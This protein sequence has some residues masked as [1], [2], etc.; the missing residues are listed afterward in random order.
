MN[1]FRISTSYLS[2]ALLLNPRAFCC[3]FSALNLLCCCSF[4]TS[5]P[6]LAKYPESHQL[7]TD[8]LMAPAIVLPLV[9]NL[10]AT[11]VFRFDARSEIPFPTAYYFPEHDRRRFVEST[12]C[13]VPASSFS[14]SLE[15]DI[16]VCWPTVLDG[17]LRRS[18]GP[19][20]SSL[21][22]NQ[23]LR[24]SLA[25][26]GGCA[27][28]LT[29]MRISKKL[30]PRPARRRVRM[31]LDQGP[32]VQRCDTL[33]PP[34]VSGCRRG[35]GPCPPGCHVSHCASAMATGARPRPSFGRDQRRRPGTQAHGCAMSR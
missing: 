21:V 12:L 13:L 24:P 9:Q 17:T 32:V 20:A 2:L 31:T 10:V 23:R 33:K 34:C 16:R 14:P 8:D 28:S 15:V 18:N 27:A 11:G 29:E 7:T 35:S 3:L 22:L 1:G 30:P 25:P 19:D 5:C 4:G 6:L 26:G